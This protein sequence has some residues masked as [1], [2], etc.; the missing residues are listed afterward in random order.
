MKILELNQK[1]LP[2]FK[3]FDIFGLMEKK[4][5]KPDLMLGAVYEGKKGGEAAGILLGHSG[6]ESIDLEWVFV[7]PLLRGKCVGEQLIT[8]VFQ[9]AEK[10]G[11]KVIHVSFPRKEFGYK[12]LCRND[13][14][15]L[16]NHGF[17]ETEE[18]E[19]IA[20]VSEFRKLTEEPDALDYDDSV[21]VESLLADETDDES[22]ENRNYD[23]TEHFKKMH[24]QWP[25]KKTGLKDCSLLPNLHRFL[26]SVL[27]GK[28]ALKVGSIGELTVAQFREGVELCEKMEHTGYLNSLS[29]TSMDYYDMDL[30]AYTLSKDH[31]SGFMLLHYNANAE[32][33]ILELLFS[34]DRE[35]HRSLAE[36][37]RYSLVAA[38]KKYPPDTTLVLPY[39][40]EL[41]APVINKLF[42]EQ[43]TT[44]G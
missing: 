33:L 9:L 26:K 28:K 42:G 12:A 41:H 34:S 35:N 31:V 8:F 39:E 30:S 6:R 44:E 24:K 10:A 21:M 3:G 32:E 14:I 17:H 7:D 4:K 36:M 29:E 22:D 43:D 5:T 2:Y 11:K 1:Q 19:M 37:I 27:E 18:G 20:E 40:K 16:R 23:T 38:N 25:V 15:F 13:R